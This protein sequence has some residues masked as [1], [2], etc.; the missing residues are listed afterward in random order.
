MKRKSIAYL[1]TASLLVCLSVTTASSALARKRKKDQKTEA[2]SSSA[3]EDRRIKVQGIMETIIFSKL[4]R[5]G[6]SV[7]L[8]KVMGKQDAQIILNLIEGG[9]LYVGAR[10]T[11]KILKQRK[12]Y[13][14]DE[15]WIAAV[16]KSSRENNDRA[17]AN[18][19]KLQSE[20]NIL[21]VQV[22]ELES[23]L[24]KGTAKEK[25]LVAMRGILKKKR[26]EAWSAAAALRGE[27]KKIEKRF[28]AKKIESEQMYAQLRKTL[29]EKQKRAEE[30]D[31]LADSF[32]S[33]SLLVGDRSDP[34][35]KSTHERNPPF[36]FVNPIQPATG[37]MPVPPF[38]RRQL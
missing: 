32:A 26:N 34:V 9:I 17:A 38:R 28:K 18:N 12:K 8:K 13:R 15:E 6:A 35:D 4:G 19:K 5:L 11:T 20:L 16:S 24:K 23:K 25:E 10:R 37:K 36:N 27:A 1:V 7:V 3:K 29:E 30:L 14:S 33:Q 22:L 31:E 2:A 21:T